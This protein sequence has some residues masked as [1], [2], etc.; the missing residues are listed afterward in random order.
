MFNFSL[1]T[2]L[3]VRHRLERLKMKDLA[4]KLAVQ[5]GLEQEIL[6]IREHIADQDGHLGEHKRAGMINI[7]EMRMLYQFKDKMNI[8]LGGLNGRLK[9]ALVEV[10][11]KRVL[12][13][14]S[15]RQRKTLEILREK[16][17]IRYNKKIAREEMIQMDEAASNQ[18]MQKRLQ[19][20]NA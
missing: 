7:L 19:E 5:Q 11:E 13:V 20:T 1:Q 14:E 10:E 15:S 18:F 9:Q 6:E 8:D 2:A 3:E 16:E 12:L 4:E 17:L